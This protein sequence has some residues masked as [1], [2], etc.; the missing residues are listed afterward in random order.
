[1]FITPR[2]H[3]SDH[4]TSDNVANHLCIP[5]IKN[6]LNK[7]KLNYNTKY[8]LMTVLRLSFPSFSFL[9]TF[10]ILNLKEIWV[11]HIRIKLHSNNSFCIINT[12]NFKPVMYIEMLIQYST[13]YLINKKCN[14]T[15]PHFSTIYYLS[16]ICHH[17]R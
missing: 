16:I 10:N 2:D 15:C 1:M 8:T 14:I 13:I 6:I 11:L 17:Y 3:T 4:L 12:F 5:C 7:Y 9:T